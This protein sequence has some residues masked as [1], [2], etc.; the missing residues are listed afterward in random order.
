MTIWPSAPGIAIARTAARSRSEKWI[1]T[2]NISRMIPMS[3]SSMRDRGVGDEAR[4]ERAEDDPGDDVADDRRQAD[5][6]G[7]EAAD[8]RGH[9]ADR[10]GGDENGLVVHGSSRAMRVG[11]GLARVRARTTTGAAGNDTRRRSGDR[12]RASARDGPSAAPW[13]SRRLRAAERGSS[14][15]GTSPGS[16]ASL[17]GGTS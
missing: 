8:E 12:Q 6:L 3:A 2:P 16:A 11:A 13:P 4:R 9:Q 15:A 5:P 14:I 1:P 17:G 10:D 7:D